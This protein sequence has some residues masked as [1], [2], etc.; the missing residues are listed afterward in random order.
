MSDQE[1]I[2]HKHQQVEESLSHKDF[3][4]NYLLET[5]N[6]F[7]YRYFS[8]ATAAEKVSAS[9][10]RVRAIEQGIKEAVKN[11]DQKLRA[12]ILELVKRISKAEGPTILNELKIDLLERDPKAGGKCQVSARISFNHP[13]HNFSKGS[14]VEK[15]SLFSFPDDYHLRNTLARHL[16]EVSALF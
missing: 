8:D 13:E 15:V 9:T 14:F 16:E 1:I 2:Q 11:P 6:S 3:F 7:A 10:F 12:G 4:E 5:L